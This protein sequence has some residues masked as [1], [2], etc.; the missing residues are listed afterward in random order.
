MEF[1]SPAVCR[2]LALDRP[3]PL[4]ARFRQRARNAV[5]PGA[6]QR[7]PDAAHVAAAECIHRNDIATWAEIVSIRNIERN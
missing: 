1:I 5:I 7:F 6:D 2:F 4:D 3:Q